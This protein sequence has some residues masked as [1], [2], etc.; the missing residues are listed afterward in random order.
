MVVVGDGKGKVGWGYGKANEVPPSVEKAR[1]EGMRS[2]VDRAARRHDDSARGRRPLRRRPRDLAAR[3]A[4]Y[5]R[6]RRL[7]R[8][9]RVRSGRHPRHP[10]QELRL[11][12]SRLAGEGHVRRAQ[13]V[14][15]QGRR[16]TLTTESPCHE[17]QRRP[18]RRPH[19]TS[20]A[21]GS[22]AASARATA[23]RPAA[24]TRANGL[25]TACRSSPIFQGGTMPLGAPHSQARLQ[26]P[27]GQ[28]GARSS[29]SAT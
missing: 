5:R 19:S 20:R 2:M 3:R 9:G 28:D 27:L 6:D 4:R 1:K 17:P 23:R 24:A 13:A 11:E 12:Q 8:A 26:Q 25:A 15:A 16:R 14:A 21:S 29:T 22:A 10:H 18:S 7:G